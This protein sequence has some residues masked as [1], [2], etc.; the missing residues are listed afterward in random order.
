VRR[1]SKQVD[2]FIDAMVRGMRPPRFRARR[3][4]V[5]VLCAAVELAASR[6]GNVVPDPS[7]LH[8]LEQACRKAVSQSRPGVR[9][10]VTRRHLLETAGLAVAAG[11]L[12]AVGDRLVTSPGQMQPDLAP[13]NGTW[14]AVARLDELTP[15]RVVRFVTPS[16]TGFIHQ[17]S[18]Q[19]TAV[20]GVCTHQGCLLELDGG[21]TLQCPCHRAA[22]S[23]AGLVISHELDFNLPPLPK[24]ATR[25]RNG[26]VEVLVAKTVIGDQSSPKET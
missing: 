4:D 25:I 18:G 21:N 5:D 15:G 14:V 16:V 3:E 17:Q 12:G 8:G 6:H 24:L 11:A 10:I 22:F 23:P 26:N 7:F 9:H 19:I 2:N 13:E 1:Q 20:S